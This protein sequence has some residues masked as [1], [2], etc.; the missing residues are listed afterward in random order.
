MPLLGC[1]STL[2]QSIKQGKMVYIHSYA[3]DIPLYI[4]IL[5][6]AFFCSCLLSLSKMY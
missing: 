5:F 1:K 3:D 6:F 2:Q 4:V